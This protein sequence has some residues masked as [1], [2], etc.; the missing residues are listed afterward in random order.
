MNYKTQDFPYKTPVEVKIANEM[1]RLVREYDTQFQLALGDNF[2][3]T[4]VENVE[5][6]RFK[7]F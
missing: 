5:D 7:V 6:K 3:F 2:Y 1:T 4:G